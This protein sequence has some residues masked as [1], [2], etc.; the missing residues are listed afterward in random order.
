VKSAIDK[1]V[2]RGAIVRPAK[3][4]EQS[5]DAMGRTRVTEV[6]LLPKQDSIVVAA[7]LS[8]VFGRLAHGSNRFQR[9][10]EEDQVDTSNDVSTRPMSASE[11]ADQLAVSLP[12]IQRWDA[13]NAAEA[14]AAEAEGRDYKPVDHPERQARKATRKAAPGSVTCFQ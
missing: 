11:R 3:K 6:Y 5:T 9:R 8:P 10:A 2:Q 13:E 1:L 14:K 12:T 4:D 7:Q